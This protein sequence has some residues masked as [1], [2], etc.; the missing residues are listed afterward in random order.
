VDRGLGSTKGRRCTVDYDWIDSERRKVQNRRGG[1][2]RRRIQESAERDGVLRW[3][4]RLWK[5]RLGEE[6]G[7]N[8]GLYVI[9]YGM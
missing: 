7:A 9:I 4:R 8:D 3:C 5:L 2:S 6:I 1:W